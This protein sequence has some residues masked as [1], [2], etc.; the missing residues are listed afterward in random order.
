MTAAS[1]PYHRSAEY[2]VFRAALRRREIAR[3]LDALHY[4]LLVLIGIR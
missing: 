3:R 4:R 1:R 2:R